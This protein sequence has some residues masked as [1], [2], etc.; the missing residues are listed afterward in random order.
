MKRSDKGVKR[1]SYFVIDVLVPGR[2][3]IDSKFCQTLKVRVAPFGMIDE[4]TRTELR[5]AA[6]LSLK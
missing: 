4:G 5:A 6:L 2:C 1:V 3:P